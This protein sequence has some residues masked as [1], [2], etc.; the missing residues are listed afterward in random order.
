MAFE[1]RDLS[2]TP[3]RARTVPGLRNAEKESMNLDRR[4]AASPAIGI[5][6]MDL[7]GLKSRT[8]ENTLNALV[9]GGILQGALQG[10]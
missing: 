8:L 10:A 5:L 1:P 4:R 9:R 3:A 6:I 2:A 7:G